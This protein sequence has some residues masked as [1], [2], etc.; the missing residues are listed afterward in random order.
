MLFNWKINERD[1][2]KLVKICDK[3]LN[4]RSLDSI[5][6]N[7]LGFIAKILNDYEEIEESRK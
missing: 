2:R 6:E 4:K 1:Y 7:F 5:Q 3:L